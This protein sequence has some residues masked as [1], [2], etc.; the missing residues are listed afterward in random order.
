[1]VGLRVNVSDKIF[2]TENKLL[3]IADRYLHINMKLLKEIFEEYGFRFYYNYAYKGKDGL[4]RYEFKIKE[5][6]IL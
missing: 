1:M 5:L 2:L 6:W 3:V 4:M